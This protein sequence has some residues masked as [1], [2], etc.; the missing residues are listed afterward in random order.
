MKIS[1][2]ILSI[3]VMAVGLVFLSM[4]TVD[5][6]EQVVITRFGKVI[7]EAV[8]E[9]GL[10]F[11][12]PVLDS[13]NRL[14]KTLLEWDGERGEIPT[15][16]KN[17][18]WV[19]TFA[20]WQIENP[21]TFI[22]TLGSLRIAKNRI[23]DI[24]NPA[25]KNVIA[26]YDLIESVRNTNREFDREISKGAE[27]AG[28]SGGDVVEYKIEAGRS[29]I[30]TLILESAGVKL[31]DFGIKLK[32][33]KIK[34]INYREDVRNSVYDRMIA[35]RMQIVGRF[36]SEG[37]GEASKIRGDKE[38]ELKKITSEAYR[39][40]QVK[41]GAADAE[42]TKIYADAYGRDPEFYSFVKSLEVYNK[43]MDKESSII[44]STDSEFF[45]YLN[46]RK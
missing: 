12:V 32:D 3:I 46:G 22:R 21:V 41:K 36:R 26:S 31:K 23:G 19:D 37:R 18:I 6:K 40:S 43:A 9:P 5:E 7:G 38:K 35:E 15:K 34:R 30:A 24:I 39:K 25:V 10:K 13:V 14:P 17:Y 44:M 4:Y 29:A 42:V 45:K 27:H 16:N 20:I 33:V 8:T 2:V 28:Y 1:G 11:K